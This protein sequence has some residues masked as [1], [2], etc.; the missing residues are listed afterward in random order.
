MEIAA[1]SLYAGWLTWYAWQK[2]FGDEPPASD[3]RPEQS[4]E[5]TTRRSPSPT[6]QHRLPPLDRDR[7]PR[8]RSPSNGQ[9]KDSPSNERAEQ[10]HRHLTELPPLPYHIR[11]NNNNRPRREYEVRLLPSLPKRRNRD[12]RPLRN[13]DWVDKLTMPELANREMIKKPP[14][15]LPNNTNTEKDG[16]AGLAIRRELDNLRSQLN[17]QQQLQQQQQLLPDPRVQLVQQQAA[18][19]LMKKETEKALITKQLEDAKRK[20][21]EAMLRQNEEE[22]RKARVAE[23][24]WKK[25]LD[26]VAAEKERVKARMEEQLAKI[27]E[28]VTQQ[29]QDFKDKEERLKAKAA[30]D[31]ER[32]EHALRKE[33][34]RVKRKLEEAKVERNKALEKAKATGDSRVAEEA[35][36]ADDRVKEYERQVTELKSERE[37]ER[38][39]YE[40]E[41]A[42]LANSWESR[43]QEVKKTEE[44]ARAAVNEDSRKKLT[45]AESEVAE[46][47]RKMNELIANARGD[48]AQYEAELGRMNAA[49]RQEKLQLE[50][51]YRGK[52]GE[53][54]ARHSE[55]LKKQ[56]EE[57]LSELSRQHSAATSASEASQQELK[58]R[59]TALTSELGTTREAKQRFEASSSQMTKAQQALLGQISEFEKKLSDAQRLAQAAQAE[60]KTTSEKLR[61]A[62][63]VNAVGQRQLDELRAAVNTASGE[64]ELL[65]STLNQ[66]KQEYDGL[67]ALAAAEVTRLRQEVERLRNNPVAG[68]KLMQPETENEQPKAPNHDLAR[69]AQEN[70]ALKQ[71]VEVLKQAATPPPGILDGMK[72]VM[73]MIQ[74]ARTSRCQMQTT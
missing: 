65:R 57:R 15:L 55:H 56:H 41:K 8:E 21:Q 38:K 44:Q 45:A 1:I 36:R 28:K 14:G 62:E 23:E 20:T 31:K 33:T 64:A 70:A 48:R 40:E 66:G 71:A 7:L 54:F 10:R 46:L 11:N 72:D 26:E 29:S 51:Q 30:E 18:N 43:L 58:D 67:Q 42:R 32:V 53:E 59:I 69:L 61:A 47:R 25:K 68:D 35:K 60:L 34:E 3:D 73:R 39:R 6:L 16:G 2:V 22:A 9:V 17:N 37:A 49:Y 12:E 52:Y 27:N 5:S 13:L 50:E 74:D 4:P 63:T 24:G 19:E